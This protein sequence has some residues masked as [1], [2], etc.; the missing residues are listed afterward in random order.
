[1]MPLAGPDITHYNISK[2]F[3]L[4]GVGGAM[5]RFTFNAESAKRSSWCIYMLFHVRGQAGTG[6]SLHAPRYFI[7]A[8]TPEKIVFSPHGGKLHFS[9]V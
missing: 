9:V 4:G 8:A 3:K 1:M 6:H 7:I 5:S 2:S